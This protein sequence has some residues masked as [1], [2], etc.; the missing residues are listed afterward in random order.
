MKILRIIFTYSII[1]LSLSIKIYGSEKR[2]AII[3]NYNSLGMEL[4]SSIK[5]GEPQ[6]VKKAL[7]EGA[8]IN[9]LDP[10]TGDTVFH[11]VVRYHQFLL[12]PLLSVKGSR[13]SISNNDG[14][15]PGREL[16]DQPTR[17]PYQLNWEQFETI[18]P[19]SSKQSIEN[20]TKNQN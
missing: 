16:L 3:D 1:M 17:T 8:N 2:K 6:R 18:N 15:T 14:V 7:E 4:L 19:T 5:H 13:A 9:Y 11:Y 20:I 12:M 10:E